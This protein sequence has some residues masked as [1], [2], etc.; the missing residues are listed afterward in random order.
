MPRKAP[1]VSRRQ[2]H[3]VFFRVIPALLAAAALVGASVAGWALLAGSAIFAGSTLTG[4]PNGDSGLVYTPITGIKVEASTLV[5]GYGCGRGAGQVFRYAVVLTYDD[6]AGPQ[7]VPAY[8][9]VFDCYTDAIFS[10]LQADDSGSLSFYLNVYA[11]DQASYP[12]ALDDLAFADDAGAVEQVAAAANWTTTCTA[13]Q[14]SG[15]SAVALCQPLEPAGGVLDAGGP[16]ADSGTTEAGSIVVDTHGFVLPEGGAITCGATPDSGAIGFDS[17]TASYG[18]TTTVTCPAPIRIAPDTPGAAYAIALGM[19]RADAQ[20]AT[21]Q[22]SATAV[23]G[24]AVQAT[25]G[26]ATLSGP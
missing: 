15:I 1:R 23:A 4:C 22:C 26:A 24:Q 5:A 20:V 2:A 19:N 8:S 21:A 14:Q 16:D 11:Y 3:L 25:C 13:T 18:Q 10:N 7:S 17:V 6:E 12:A 9:G